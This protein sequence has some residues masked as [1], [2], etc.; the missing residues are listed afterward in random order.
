MWRYRKLV[1]KYGQLG[2][3]DLRAN[4]K[5]SADLYAYG[6]KCRRF[7]MYENFSQIHTDTA[8]DYFSNNNE[9]NNNKGNIVINK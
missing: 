4:Y 6:A 8:E 5:M 3:V 7:V 9:N 2:P 1:P